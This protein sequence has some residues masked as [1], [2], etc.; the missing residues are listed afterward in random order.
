[1]IGKSL[2]ACALSVLLL[3][4]CASTGTNYN[5]ESRAATAAS[6]NTQL[7][8]EYLRKGE[9]DLSLKKLQKAIELKPD[10]AMAHDV[11]A[12]LYERVG[13]DE[14]AEKH[15]RRGLSLNP[16]NAEGHSNY[17]QFLCHTGR[18]KQAE[19]Q[20]QLAINDPFYRSPEIPLL[21]AGMC[22]AGIPD[23][24]K[25]EQYFRKALDSNPKFAP[26]LLQM[27]QLGYQKQDYLK[28]RAYLQRFA[29]VN[30]N[31]AESLWLGVRIEYALKDH[32]AWGNYALQLRRLHPDSEQAALLVEWE[33]E[34]R[35]GN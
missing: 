8:I 7:G 11:I 2:Y 20:F 15:Y 23:E 10:Y 19:E 24:E 4:G 12:I 32:Q 9:Y 22:M 25:A 35:T 29:A 1:M 18:H 3:S 27:A 30:Q 17:G 14:L 16:D 33:N 28:A 34:R 31:T 13:E 6:A 5:D 21:N 26:A